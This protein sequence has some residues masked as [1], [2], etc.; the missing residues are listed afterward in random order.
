M[1][2]SNSERRREETSI[3]RSEGPDT[4]RVSGFRPRRRRF[5]GLKDRGFEGLK[6]RGSEGLKDGGS[7]GPVAG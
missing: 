5:P 1:Q 7:E 2:L 6:V 4:F 3:L